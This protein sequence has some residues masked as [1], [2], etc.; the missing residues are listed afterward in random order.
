[1]VEAARQE[2]GARIERPMTYV[3]LL[4]REYCYDVMQKGSVNMATEL[5][6][7]PKSHNVGL[8]HIIYHM[9]FTSNLAFQCVRHVI[10]VHLH[11]K[12]G[13]AFY[14][15]LAIVKPDAHPP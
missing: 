4:E 1:V 2:V 11:C 6:I 7:Q 15:Y 9:C 8:Y 12:P 5:C 3:N 14:L 10:A 13:G